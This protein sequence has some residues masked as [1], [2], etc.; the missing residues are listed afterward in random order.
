MGTPCNV[1]VVG[2]TRIRIDDILDFPKT[3]DLELDSS[4]RSLSQL[5]KT[6]GTQYLS[7]SK[8]DTVLSRSRLTFI[9]PDI[10][11]TSHSLNGAR[12]AIFR[13]IASKDNGKKVLLIE[14]WSSDG[15]NK[16]EE[17]EVGDKHGDW[18]FD[19]MSTELTRS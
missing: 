1:A 8:D 18:Y 10:L 14:I 13:S 12:F 11:F 16:Q 9:P 4:H 19:G 6:R 17:I 3:T 7:L 5:S 2:G 15:G